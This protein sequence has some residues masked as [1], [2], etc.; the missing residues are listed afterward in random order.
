MNSDELAKSANLYL[1]Q[2]STN[3]N[4][5]VV[6]LLDSLHVIEFVELIENNLG[7]VLTDIEITTCLNLPIGKVGRY[8]HEL[9]TS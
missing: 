8:L 4:S 7:R 3:S 5:I 1:E 6:E 2:Y 9:E